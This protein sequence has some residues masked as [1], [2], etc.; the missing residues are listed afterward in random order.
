M[1]TT[2]IVEK[3]GV[4]EDAII[5]LVVTKDVNSV[6]QI[7]NH[8]YGITEEREEYTYSHAKTPEERCVVRVTVRVPRRQKVIHLSQ[9]AESHEMAHKRINVSVRREISFW[10]FLL[11]E[12]RNEITHPHEAIPLE[13]QRRPQLYHGG[14]SDV[15]RMTSPLTGQT[16]PH[17]FN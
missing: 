6:V 16:H 17:K 9:R 1:T 15:T 13:K 12:N 7:T 14:E 2:Y 4:I 5:D 3:D 11:G 8:E 10:R